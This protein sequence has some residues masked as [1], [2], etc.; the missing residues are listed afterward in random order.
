[1]M[2]SFEIIH[3][4]ALKSFQWKIKPVEPEGLNRNRYYSGTCTISDASLLINPLT[5]C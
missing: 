4:A 2:N 1:M 5:A 3:I